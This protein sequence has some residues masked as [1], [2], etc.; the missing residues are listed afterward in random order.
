[1]ADRSLPVPSICI[2]IQQHAE[3]KEEF[4][5]VLAYYH[6]HVPFVTVITVSGALGTVTPYIQRAWILQASASQ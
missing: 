6:S 4:Y 1:M 2:A 5:V 3:E